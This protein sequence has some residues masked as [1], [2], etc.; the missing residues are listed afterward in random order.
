MYPSMHSERKTNKTWDVL[1]SQLAPL[2]K[3][4]P[5]NSPHW[6]SNIVLAYEPVWAI[7]TGINSSP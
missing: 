5:G 6:Q 7:G 2:I 1:E 4:F 3:A